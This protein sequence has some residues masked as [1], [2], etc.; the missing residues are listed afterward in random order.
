MHELPKHFVALEPQI[1]VLLSSKSSENS[2]VQILHECLYPDQSMNDLLSNTKSLQHYLID[3]VMKSQVNILLDKESGKDSAHVY[4][5]CKERMQALG[6]MPF[7]QPTISQ[8][9]LEISAWRHS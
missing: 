3:K 7:Q 1:D 9:Y 2:V 6:Q 5:P 8:S 4:V